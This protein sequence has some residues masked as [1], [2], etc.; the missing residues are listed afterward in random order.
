MRKGFGQTLLAP[1]IGAL[2]L[3]GAPS[4]TLAAPE[5]EKEPPAAEGEKGKQPEKEAGKDG[6]APQKGGDQAAPPKSDKKGDNKDGKDGDDDYGRRYDRDDGHY[7]HDRYGRHY[8][9]SHRWDTHPRY[10]RYGYRGPGYY[11]DCGYYGPDGYQHGYY[12]SPDACSYQYG[13]RGDALRSNLSGAEV[14]PGPGDPDAVGFANLF[15]DLANGRL[16]YRLGYDGTPDRPTAGHIHRGDQG[17]TGPPAIDLHTEAN[18][19][20]GCV[21][22][23]PTALRNLRDYPEAFYMQLHTAEHPDGALRGQLHHT[24]R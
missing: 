12:D 18:G 10:Y 13:P 1:V 19:D 4:A 2:L 17:R 15:V 5:K 6:K 7:D 22:A 14:V 23:D 3:L 20:E 24:G 21:G 16:C 11:D 9:H 8:R